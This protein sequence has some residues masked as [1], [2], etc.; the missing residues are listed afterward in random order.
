MGAPTEAALLVL[1]EKLGVADPAKQQQIAKQRKTDPDRHPCGAVDA[2]NQRYEV[3]NVLVCVSA[4]GA[5][6]AIRRQLL[7]TEED[8]V[9]H[10]PQI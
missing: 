9:A 10:G 4:F 5:C 3:Q 1:T 6:F 2:Y 8:H 7:M